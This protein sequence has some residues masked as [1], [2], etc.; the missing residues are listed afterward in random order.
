MDELPFRN[1]CLNC[2]HTSIAKYALSPL[3]PFEIQCAPSEDGQSCW[4]CCNRN[5]ACDTPSMGMQGDVYDLSAI[6]EWTRKF[7]SVD[8]KFLWN[9]GFRLAIC[10]ASKELCIKFELAEMI[11]RRHHMLSVIDWNDTSEVQN[12]DIDNY[13][14]FLAERR[15]A[16]PTLTLPATGIM[17]R[18]DFVTYNPERL[19][20]L[21]SGDPGF[22]VWLEAKTAFLN[23]LQQRSISIYGGEDRKNGKRRLAFLKNGFPAELN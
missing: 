1:W 23:C 20:R 8:G 9:L 12:T 3:R 5:I 22:L 17:N 21:C 6:L 2:L 10:E 19:L 7:W 11:H 15:G 13:R 4:Q 16:L 18:Q 14:R